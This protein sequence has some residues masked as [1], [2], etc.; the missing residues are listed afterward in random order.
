MMKYNGTHS[1]IIPVISTPRRLAFSA[2]RILLFTLLLWGSAAAGA[3]PIPGTPV[4]VT[5]QTFVLMVMALTLDW[6]EAASS[7]ILYWTAG[8]AGLP[9]FANGGSL[10]SLI[11]PGGGFLLGF[12]PAVLITSALKGRRRTRWSTP[13]AR[14]TLGQS[15]AIDAAETADAK[16][17]A[18]PALGRNAVRYALTAARYF[19][20][21][22]I[23][24]I[25][26][27]Y[28]FGFVMQSLLTHVPLHTVALAS[29]GFVAGDLIKATVASLAV[30]AADVRR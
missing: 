20:A 29:M 25:V 1:A 15:L 26:V 28:A 21:C 23:G 13:D 8:A 16:A 3:I 4:P 9:V 24:C 2:G 27:D 5:L 22:L 7:V 12:L 10:A 6:R 19:M 17:E 14:M 30:A 18:T 11:G